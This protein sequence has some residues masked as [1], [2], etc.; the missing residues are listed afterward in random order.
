LTNRKKTMPLPGFCH[1]KTGLEILARARENPRDITPRLVLADWLEGLGSS[2]AGK[3]ARIIRRSLE[4]DELLLIKP[5]YAARLHPLVGF[6]RGWP[7]A[8]SFDQSDPVAM[9]WLCTPDTI[10]IAPGNLIEMLPVPAMIGENGPIQP[11][12]ISK[13]VITKRQWHGY[14]GRNLSSRQNPNHPANGVPESKV[15][16]FCQALS[17][18][19]GMMV[20]VPSRSE[21]DHACQTTN[22]TYKEKIGFGLKSVVQ[23]K[24]MAKYAWTRG[25]TPRR[26][27]GVFTLPEVCTKLPNPWGIF[28]MC[29]L[30][31]QWCYVPWLENPLLP[32]AAWQ[33]AVLTRYGY[34]SVNDAP[35]AKGIRIMARARE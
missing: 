31:T 27:D 21:W 2:M 32:C 18:L 13:T 14:L 33:I 3:F 8:G 30:V 34:R 24:E 5:R 9:A 26:E 29:G 17:A 11:F 1:D 20:S 12:L 10:P 7:H 28:D 4:N 35:A 19:S 22:S 25:G 15:L 6:L 16:D 23:S